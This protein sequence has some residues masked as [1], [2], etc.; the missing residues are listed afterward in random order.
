MPSDL[1]LPATAKTLDT[2][3]EIDR[4]DL[5]ELAER[6][7]TGPTSFVARVHQI[8]MV[9]KEAL[10][11]IDSATKARLEADPTPIPLTGGKSLVLT[12]VHG[13]KIADMEALIDALRAQEPET[14]L[15]VVKLEE[16]TTLGAIE[17]AMRD[18]A[19]GFLAR[20][21]PDVVAPTVARSLKVI[22]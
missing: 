8:A 18:R 20:L 5:A 2:L 1:T 13:R 15:K 19:P 12:T 17:K 14:A 11:V 6:I 21:S 22:G 7:R 16:S 4:L 3:M 10:P 9:L